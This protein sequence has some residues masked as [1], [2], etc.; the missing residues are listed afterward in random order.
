MYKKEWNMVLQLSAFADEASANFAE[1]IAALREERIPFIE[2]RGLDGKNVADL[3]D[4][5][6]ETYA[7]MLKKGGIRVWSIGSPLGKIGIDDDFAQHLRKAER[8]YRLAKIFATDKVRVFSFYT[9]SPEKDAEKVYARM[10][11]MA[12]LAEKYGVK[13]YHENEKEIFGD[14]AERCLSLLKRVP[15]LGCVFDPAN[16]VQCGEDIPAALSLLG[17]R[18]DYY[19]VKDAL[20]AGGEVV[21]AGLGDGHV[22]E[23]IAQ[24]GGDTVL[25]LEPH[26]AVFEGYAGIDHTQLKNKFAYPS[27]RAAFAAAAEALR[28]LL[29]GTGFRE[30][31]EKWIK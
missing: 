16:F 29:K 5:E 25:T 3:T 18:I 28:G 2:L 10:A 24:I 21:P 13:L 31:N 23:M 22:A 11:E 8:V 26:L 9:S 17:G 6:A 30:E 1:Q 12:A 27:Q 20:Y 15:G 19:H 4:A 14:R 7:E